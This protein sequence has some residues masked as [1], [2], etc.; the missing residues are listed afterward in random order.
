MPAMPTSRGVRVR[1]RVPSAAAVAFLAVS[2]LTAAETRAVD[3]GG[4]R[5][6]LEGAERIWINRRPVRDFPRFGEG[7]PE[8][9]IP[10]D[11]A[12]DGG[13]VLHHP[14]F[15]VDGTWRSKGKRGF[16]AAI[17]GEP[18]EFY[19]AFLTL[20]VVNTTGATIEGRNFRLSVAGTVRRGNRLTLRTHTVLTG[21][22]RLRSGRTVRGR[23]ETR[24]RF[25]G[26]LVL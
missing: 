8:P 7:K 13:F 6:E 11:F 20:L 22:M 16:Q 18:L 10:V 2:S 4:T 21:P 19:S 12:D 23:V 17:T 15:E 9:A 1:V 25:S 3:L 5:W 24:G 26:T 14:V